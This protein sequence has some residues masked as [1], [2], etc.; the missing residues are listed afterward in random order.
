[1]IFLPGGCVSGSLQWKQLVDLAKASWRSAMISVKQ[2][3]CSLRGPY[4]KIHKI[5]YLWVHTFWAI[6]SSSF[7]L[8]DNTIKV[9]KSSLKHRKSAK[10]PWRRN[11]IFSFWSLSN[12][13]F[14]FLPS[15]FFSFFLFVFLSFCLSNFHA[16][17]FK[18]SFYM[19]E[20]ISLSLIF[21][22]N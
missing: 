8:A 6:L 7:H 10:L 4:E 12:C 17:D 14:V 5:R 15:S 2:K 13:L 19:N 22:S 3:S 1:M 11:I 9:V 16:L 18:L 21:L 20:W